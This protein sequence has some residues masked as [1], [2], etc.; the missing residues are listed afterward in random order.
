MVRPSNASQNPGPQAIAK[1]T[2]PIEPTGATKRKKP[3][4]KWSTLAERKIR[5]QTKQSAKKTALPRSAIRDAIRS[6]TQEL[7][8]PAMRW[9]KDSVSALHL[10]TEDYIIHHLAA[11]NVLA[12][13]EQGKPTLT[14]KNMKN[15]ETIKKLIA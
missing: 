3:K 13:S 6:I 10:G 5:H 15:L 11:A 2:K 14:A 7:G 4:F 12:V 9:G 1:T 8:L